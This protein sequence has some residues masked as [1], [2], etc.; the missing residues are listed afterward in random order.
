MAMGQSTTVSKADIAKLAFEQRLALAVRAT[1]PLVPA[2]ARAQLQQLLDP[3]TLAIVA[4]V[5]IAWGLSH[6]VGVGEI[7]DMVL[8]IAG[9]LALGATAWQAAEEL[10]AFVKDVNGSDIDGAAKHL[11]RAISLIGIQAVLMI[12]L[13]N[14]PKPYRLS[15]SGNSRFAIQ[16]LNV[17]PSPPL[18]PGRWFYKPSVRRVPP[19][20]LGTGTMGQTSSWGDVDIELNLSSADLKATK[21]HELVH[22][23]LT[24]K[25]YF[26]RNLRVQIAAQGYVRSV[27]LRY[28]EEAMAETYAQL[29]VSGINLNSLLRGITFP[30]NGGYT[31]T[32][33]KAGSEVAGILLG[34]VNV[35]GMVWNVWMIQGKN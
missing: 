10:V 14:A 3:A 29:R 7:A 31:I 11:A 35:G 17:G 19:G 9:W 20:S 30:L 26:L 1:L 22:S 6:F 25:F 2:E 16:Q 33:T 18:P 12:L 13:H 23:F 34:P 15:K 28:V 24:P 4:G 5:L 32:V 8:L 21:M 27:F